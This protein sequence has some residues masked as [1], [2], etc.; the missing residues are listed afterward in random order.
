ML[1]ESDRL[2]RLWK[3]FTEDKFSVRWSSNPSPEIELHNKIGASINFVK[4]FNNKFPDCYIKP[5][6]GAAYI[7]HRIDSEEKES[8]DAYQASIDLTKKYLSEM[9][10]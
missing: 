8:N 3:C 10:I 9:D 1:N 6:Y 5:E 7:L 4:K 2:E